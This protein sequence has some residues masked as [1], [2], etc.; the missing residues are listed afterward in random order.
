LPLGYSFIRNGVFFFSACILEIV[1]KIFIKSI[2]DGLAPR[3]FADAKQLKYGVIELL[4]IRLLEFRHVSKLIELV[5]R[6]LLKKGL[7]P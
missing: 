4:S 2:A 7:S 5:H 1:L 3:G 6:S